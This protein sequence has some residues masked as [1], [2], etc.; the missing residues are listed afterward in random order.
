MKNVKWVALLLVVL[1]VFSIAAAGC[2]PKTQSSEK[3]IKIGFIG[4]LTGDVK[5]FGTSTQNAFLL[6]IKEHNNTVAGYTIQT[7][8]GDDAN[9]ATQATAVATKLITQDKVSAIVGSVTSSCTIPISVVSEQYKVP[10][11]SP[12]ATNPKVTM[13]PDRKTYAFR[14]C[15]IDPFQGTVAATF[16]V[17]NLKAKT[18]AALYDQGNDYSV[19]L[20]DF[21]SQAFTKLGG[22]VLDTEAYS[23]NDT[24]FSAQ[25][26]KIAV[27]KPD[28]LYL[29]DYYQKVSLIGKQARDKGIKA[30]FMGGDGWDSSDIDWATMDGGYYSNHYSADDPSPQVQSWVKD[31][32]AAYGSKPDALATLAYDATNIVL[33]GIED[34][35][36]NDPTKIRD[37]I[38]NL[39]D[40][41]TVTGKITFGADGNPIKAAVILKIDGKNKKSAFAASIQ[42]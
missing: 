24:D 20:K 18:A 21:F 40:F 19:G 1:F 4:P 32:Q 8:I 28:I 31:Y 2:A 42:P 30:V 13:D 10:F 26:T 9:T 5:T 27:L 25:L 15:F 34:A 39:K 23:K 33:K 16:V 11:V 22:K 3:V 7:V 37:A 29:P 41:Q 6:A 12:T 38:Q 14:A 35:Q 17:N 36:S